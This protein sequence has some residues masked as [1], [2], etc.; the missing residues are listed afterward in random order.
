MPGKKT[1]QLQLR[2]GQWSKHNYKRR[3]IN[4]ITTAGSFE[5]Q[6]LVLNAAITDPLVVNVASSIGVNLEE[7]AVHRD[8]LINM[9]TCLQR[10]RTTTNKNN[11]IGNNRRMLVNAIFTA[12]IKT[13]P[14]NTDNLYSTKGRGGHHY[15]QGINKAHKAL[16]ITYSGGYRSISRGGSQT[17]DTVHETFPQT[18]QK[19]N[20]TRS[21][22]QR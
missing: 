17:I 21:R 18:L 12:A 2:N 11:K 13:P 22:T 16:G 9:R 8:I 20:H 3:L 1:H 10:A 19:S 5:Q 4:K 14:K 6:R 15:P 7:A